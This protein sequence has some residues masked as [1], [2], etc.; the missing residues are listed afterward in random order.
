MTERERHEAEAVD[1]Y[2]DQ[3]GSTWVHHSRAHPAMNVYRR[4]YRTAGREGVNYPVMPVDTRAPDFF[5][6]PM[7]DD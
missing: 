2:I 4:R 7:A 5:W 6:G 3:D 1:S